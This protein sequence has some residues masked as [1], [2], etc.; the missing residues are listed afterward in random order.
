MYMKKTPTLE[1]FMAQQKKPMTYTWYKDEAHFKAAQA[2]MP[3]IAA[4]KTYAEFL[5][6]SAEFE[7]QLARK[8]YEIIKV[9]LDL[10]EFQAWCREHNKEMNGIRCGRHL[11]Y[12]KQRKRSKGFMSDDYI[13][14]DKAREL[15][16]EV[17]EFLE[18]RDRVTVGISLGYLIATEYNDQ[19]MDHILGI[20]RSLR[21]D[22]ERAEA[23]L[24]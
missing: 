5:A 18:G 6:D 11:A 21:A 24:N 15:T 17:G 8:G 22:I 12:W 1:E 4:G 9:P 2:L 3:D 14:N 7:R 23:R 19:E 10:A 13:M 16:N 20:A